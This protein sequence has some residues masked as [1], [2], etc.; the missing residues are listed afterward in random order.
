MLTD[1]I[2]GFMK[3]TIFAL[4]TIGKKVAVTNSSIFIL[5]T[6]R[7]NTVYS[8]V[9]CLHSGH[10]FTNNAITKDHCV[11]PSPTWE[12]HGGLHFPSLYGVCCG[13]TISS[14]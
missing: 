8:F 2:K 6:F 5:F 7:R 9:S 12:Q 3:V 1:K 13:E 4:L 10:C 11:L 14:T